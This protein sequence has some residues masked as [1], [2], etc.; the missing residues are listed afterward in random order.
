[1]IRLRP[2]TA[3]DLAIFKQWLSRPHVAKWYHDPA[4]WIEEIEK[5]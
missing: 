2:M 4:D 3:G 5:Q 1:M